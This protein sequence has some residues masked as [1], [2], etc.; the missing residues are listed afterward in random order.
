M[1]NMLRNHGKSG[2]LFTVLLLLCWGTTAVNA[3]TS[4]Q[5]AR[6]ALNSTVV[7]NMQAVDGKNSQGSGFFVGNRLIATNHHVI[8]EATK[9]TVKLVGTEQEYAIEGYIAID[10]A[11]D[12]AIVK[13]ETLS[14]PPLPLGDSDTVQIG[15][16]IY[17]IG[18]PRGLE[19][20]FS[21]GIISNIQLDGDSGIQGEVIQ[22]T[23]P[24]SRG[25]SGGAV[26]NSKGEVIGIAASIRKDGQNLNFAIPVHALKTLFTRAGPL[27]ALAAPPAPLKQSAFSNLLTLI[28]LSLTAF[29]VLHF[30]PTVTVEGWITGAGVAVGIGILKVIGTEI[31]AHPSLPEGIK[32]FFAAP[33]PNDVGHAINCANCFLKLLPHL[34]KLPIY[35]VAT[36]FLLG[37][38]NK[39]VPTFELNGFFNTYLVALLIIVA[40][41]VLHAFIPTP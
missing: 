28:L 21:D 6:N 31:M 3:Q 36:T 20:T 16:I 9:G 10:K 8:D 40:E 26:L 18:N 5:I 11:R 32:V 15:E 4:E 1:R 22:M 38:A 41:G 24:I 7:L 12:L 27:Q 34:L 17:A 25:S 13:V 19:G 14:A 35:I 2:H 39:V 23:A 37:I 30:L 33:F 29:G